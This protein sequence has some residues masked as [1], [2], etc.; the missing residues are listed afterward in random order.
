MMD[1][2]TKV[3]TPFTVNGIDNSKDQPFQGDKNDSHF[4]FLFVFFVKVLSDMDSAAKT[5]K[6]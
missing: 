2:P 4:R 3:A 5:M 1:A 6:K